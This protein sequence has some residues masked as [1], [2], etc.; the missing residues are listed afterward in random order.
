MITNFK[1]ELGGERIVLKRNWFSV[2]LARVIFS[3]IDSN[4]DHLAPWFVWLEATTCVEDTLKFL[5]DC[6][7]NYK[8]GERLEYGIYIDDKY[9]GSIGIFD[10][11][12]VK[13]SAEIGYWL[14]SKFTRKGYM[15]EAIGI[16]ERELFS[17]WGLNRIQI[18]CD[19][20]NIA[21]R[22]VAEKCGFIL[23]GTLREDDFSNFHNAFRNTHILSKLKSD[24]DKN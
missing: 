11:C 20:N 6:D 8:S 18:K 10:I 3:V 17:S 1:D 21:S 12:K 23:E 7:K 9:V 14:S 16:V 19:V 2:K 13:R 4:R 22:R 24:F 15:S 5:L